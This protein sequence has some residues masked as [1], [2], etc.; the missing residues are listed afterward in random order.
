MRF[1][2][3]N[4]NVY[5]YKMRVLTN[6]ISNIVTLLFCLPNIKYFKFCLRLSFFKKK[7]IETVWMHFVI[8]YRQTVTS[9]YMVREVKRIKMS[10]KILK[11][12][13]SVMA[14]RERY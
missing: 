11:I 14:N 9:E 2:V 10:R 5:L 7:K 8:N 13:N 3:Q 6:T 12:H 1:F 4:E